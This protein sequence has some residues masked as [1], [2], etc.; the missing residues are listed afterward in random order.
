MRSKRSCSEPWQVMQTN[1]P[2][3][4]ERWRW[5]IS[6]TAIIALLLSQTLSLASSLCLGATD[7]AELSDCRNNPFTPER[8]LGFGS[9][10]LALLVTLRGINKQ[11]WRP[12]TATIWAWLRRML[13]LAAA[14]LSTVLQLQLVFF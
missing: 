9:A 6:I 12:A 2:N 4:D 7:L 11:R 14:L 10:L 1:R 13:C 3:L 5:I 8:L